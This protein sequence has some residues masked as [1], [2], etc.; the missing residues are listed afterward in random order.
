[1]NDH[2]NPAWRVPPHFPLDEALARP[3]IKA[4]RA[5]RFFDWCSMGDLCVACEIAETRSAENTFRQSVA[6]A[7]SLGEIEQLNRRTDA[8]YRITPK[9]RATLVELHATY[10]RNLECA[11]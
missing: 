4:L 3:R 10:A 2:R 5:L 6:R 8:L 11:A 7:V 9:G 1:M